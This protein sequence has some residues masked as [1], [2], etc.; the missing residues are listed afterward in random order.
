MPCSSTVE[1]SKFEEGARGA[2][3]RQLR[4]EV[5]ATIE[6]SRAA[7]HRFLM[8]D[9]DLAITMLCGVKFEQD[10]ERI[11]RAITI[12]E[13]VLATVDRFTPGTKATGA[14]ARA[15]NARRRETE[16]LLRTTRQRAREVGDWGRR[17]G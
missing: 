10:P 8:V 7:G 4:A 14:K 17:T 13:K 9:M 15:L 2:E 1:S 16:A 11:E 6:R 3:Q 5:A 12:A